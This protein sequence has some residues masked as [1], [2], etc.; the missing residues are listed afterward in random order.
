MATIPSQ[1]KSD[2]MDLIREWSICSIL[3]RPVDAHVWSLLLHETQTVKRFTRATE[4]IENILTVRKCGVAST[5]FVQ[6]PTKVRDKHVF[7]FFSIFSS[8]AVFMYDPLVS[9]LTPIFFLIR[10]PSKFVKMFNGPRFRQFRTIQT[11]KKLKKG[12]KNRPALEMCD[13]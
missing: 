4:R 13:F 11:L 8:W 6:S 2:V 7:H 10:G 1:V 9:S 5:L 3:C 12:Y